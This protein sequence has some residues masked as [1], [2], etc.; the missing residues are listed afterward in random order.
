MEK[1]GRK[2]LPLF[3]EKT[4]KI[5]KSYPKIQRILKQMSTMLPLKRIIRIG[6]SRRQQTLEISNNPL[7]RTKKKP[8]FV[9]AKGGF[10]CMMVT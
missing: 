6:D 9:E 4:K 8:P 3:Y 1:R 10:P 2:I 5:N 7:F